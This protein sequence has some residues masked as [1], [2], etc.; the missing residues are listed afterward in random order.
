[1]SDLMF[2]GQ[3]AGLAGEGVATKIEP[4]VLS[5]DPLLHA[6]ILAWKVDINDSQHSVN[7]GRDDLSGIAAVLGIPYTP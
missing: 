3:D 7:S 6:I 1:M 5:K 4:K 2:G